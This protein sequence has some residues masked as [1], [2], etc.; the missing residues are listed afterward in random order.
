MSEFYAWA[1]TGQVAQL[2]AWS[3]PD[4]RQNGDGADENSSVTITTRLVEQQRFLLRARDGREVQVH[5]VDSR[6]AFQ[7]G[8]IAT[9]VWAAREGAVHGHCIFVDNH[10][11]GASSRLNANLRHV[12]PIVKA[13]RIIPFGALAALPAA[14]ALTMWLL[15]PGSLSQVNLSVILAGAGAACVLL[16]LVGAIV[17]KLVFEYLRSEDDEKIW[18]AVSRAMAA[19]NEQLQRQPLRVMHHL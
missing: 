17:A 8:Q 15:I 19:D 12:R 6:I 14:L 9:A 7:N 16:F 1:V 2:Q 18:A 5:L 11:T 10:S 3:N 13:S 4:D